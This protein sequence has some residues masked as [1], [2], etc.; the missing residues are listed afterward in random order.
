MTKNDSGISYWQVATHYFKKIFNYK[1]CHN[2]RDLYQSLFIALPFLIGAAFASSMVN[3]WMDRLYRDLLMKGVNGSAIPDA[4]IQFF[5]QYPEF[6]I[7]V[8]DFNQWSARTCAI[9]ILIIIILGGRDACWRFRRAAFTIGVMYILRSICVSLTH[10]PNPYK[11]C[12]SPNVISPIFVDA[13]LIMIQVKISCGDVFFSGHTIIYTTAMV[14]YLK[15]NI[16]PYNSL[17]YI[18][19]FVMVV[20]CVS[21][22]VGLVVSSFHY[23]IDVIISL[24]LTSLTWWNYHVVVDLDY[25]KDTWY[26]K[27]I[28]F[29]DHHP[30][31]HNYEEL[32]MSISNR[33]ST[34]IHSSASSNN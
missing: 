14:M 4:I 24:I 7:Q 20:F 5:N 31:K 18:V 8:G 3:A 2:K 16:F 17:N 19:K 25:F 10:P 11:P 28:R 12:L 32:P 30:T 29:Y 33:Q 26:G 23:S 22:I 15:Y 34:F 13:I 1:P 6:Q 21:N 27:F 9:L